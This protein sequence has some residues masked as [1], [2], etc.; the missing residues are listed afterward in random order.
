MANEKPS[1]ETD[2]TIRTEDLRSLVESI[3]AMTPQRKLRFSEI[4]P[5]SKFNPTG[6]RKRKLDRLVYQNGRR[7]NV[8]LMF[9]EE[10]KLI[11]QIVPGRYIDG[12]VTIRV[13][14][15]TNGALDQFHIEYANKTH[16]QRLANAAHWRSL[17]AMLRLCHDEMKARA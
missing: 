3:K 14:E 10:L 2:T 8:K 12:L 17:V 7:A 16:D 6:N 4:K 13:V 5:V 11:G 9:D 1:P 15:G